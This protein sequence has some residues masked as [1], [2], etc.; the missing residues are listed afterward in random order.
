M[1]EFFDFLIFINKLLIGVIFPPIVVML[2][3]Y[4]LNCKKIKLKNYLPLLLLLY[5][6]I[7]FLAIKVYLTL[8]GRMTTM[9]YCYDLIFPAIIIS[10]PGL[11]SV[12][13]FL[14]LLLKRISLFNQKIILSLLIIGISIGSIAKA[15][16]PPDIKPRTEQL[17][18]DM[19]RISKD[20]KFVLLT[21]YEPDTF[22]YLLADHNIKVIKIDSVINF[23]RLEYFENALKYISAKYNSPVFVAMEGK[24]TE[25]RETFKKTG[26]SFPLELITE[27]RSK[28]KHYVLYI[29]K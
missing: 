27:T 9:R 29:Y 22:K 10:I 21:Q 12:R 24:D 16:S 8:T 2:V 20:D 28:K 17:I 15:L 14:F 19:L 13:D 7:S 1:T 23:N 5:I 3:F 6:F 18:Q 25:F 11:Y 26:I 4:A